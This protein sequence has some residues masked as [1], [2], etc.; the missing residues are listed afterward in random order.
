M[1]GNVIRSPTTEE[2]RL[3][4]RKLRE[5]VLTPFPVGNLNS[6]QGMARSY[7]MAKPIIY[8]AMYGSLYEVEWL[9]PLPE[10]RIV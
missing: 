8:G 2:I 9:R 7:R 5:M 4:L 1:S 6:L 3:D 10:G